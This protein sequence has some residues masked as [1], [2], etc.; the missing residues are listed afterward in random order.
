MGEFK[1][2]SEGARLYGR[3]EPV[4]AE[5]RRIFERDTDAFFEAVSLQVQALRSSRKQQTYITSVYRYWGESN[6]KGDDIDWDD[7]PNVWA[8]RWSAPLVAHDRLQLGAGGPKA[9]YGNKTRIKE[10]ASA[11][12][13][14][15]T[16][17]KPIEWG[18]SYSS[19]FTIEFQLPETSP[20]EAA[21]RHIVDILERLESL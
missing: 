5:M 12:E 11:G 6:V 2:F 18:G 16:G 1:G 3:N 9:I 20:H 14:L 21:A 7:K 10:F 15:A 17:H 13:Q 4:V 19:L 8:G